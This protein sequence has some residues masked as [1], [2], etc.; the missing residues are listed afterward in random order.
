MNTPVIPAGKKKQMCGVNASLDFAPMVKLIECPLEVPREQNSMLSLIKSAMSGSA[1]PFDIYL[2]MTTLE[3]ISL[4]DPARRLVSVILNFIACKDARIWTT[5]R[6]TP[7]GH[8]PGGSS[9]AGAFCAFNYIT[10]TLNQMVE[11]GSLGSLGSGSLDE[12]EE[13]EYF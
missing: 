1:F 3:S 6:L 13:G 9:H 5:Q 2:P 4:P 12:E 8:A 10:P 11:E 7:L